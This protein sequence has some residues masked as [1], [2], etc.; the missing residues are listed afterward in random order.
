MNDAPDVAGAV[1][2]SVIAEDSG[3]RLI[4]QAELLVNVTDVDG[5]SLTAANLAI[6]AGAGTLVDNNDGTWSFTPAL[7][8]DTSASFSFQVTDGFTSVANSASLDI[9]PVDDAPVVTGPVTLNA[10][11][12][13]SGVRLI[14]QAELLGNVGDV[15]GPSLTASLSCDRF[16]RGHAGQQQQR[17][18]ELHAGGE[19]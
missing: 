4:T 7:N 6:I 18:L 16:R 8:D 15:D 2:L 10:I 14:T 11:A 5:P 13:D 1:T 9:T 12:E 3:A 19:R 17:D